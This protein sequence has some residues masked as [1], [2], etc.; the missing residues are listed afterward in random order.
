MKAVVFA[1]RV[2][3]AWVSSLLAV[4]V[5]APAAKSPEFTSEIR[6]IL[7]A[8]CW[9]CH[10]ENSP[11]ASLSLRTPESILKGGK[12]G[13][14]VKPGSSA[15]SLLIEKVVSKAMPPGDAKLSPAEITL[16]RSWVDRL[17][18]AAEREVTENDVLPIFQ[19]RCVVCHGKRK[20]EAGLDLRSQASRLRGGKSGPALVPGKPDQSLL[21]Q[22]ISSGQMPP[23]KLLFEYFVRPPTSTEVETLRKWIA[24][25][26][27][28]A[29]KEVVAETANDPLVSDQDRAFWSFQPP[30]RPAIPEVKNPDIVRN[31]IDAFLL[32]KLQAKNLTFS[33]AA[34][35]LVLLRRACLDLTGLPP[36]P[37]QIREYLDDR[38]PDAYERL[39]DRLLASPQYGERWAQFWLN[40]AGYADSEGIIDED[41]IRPNAWRYRDYVIRS[42]NSDKPYDQFLTE[43]IAGD[44]LVNYKHAKEITP[45]IIDKLVATGFLRLVP[46]GTYSPANG[47]VAERMNVIA[48]EIEVLSSSVMGL[49]V[50]CA[51]CHNHKYDPIP[52]RD[53]YRLSAILQTAYDP[54]DWVKPT[55]RNLDVAPESDRREVASFNEPIE[56]AIKR[57][58]KSLEEKAAPLR[59]KV[60][61]DRLASL[62]G[63]VRGDLQALLS[64]EASK[65]TPIQVYLADKFQETLKVTNEDLAKQFPEFKTESDSTNKSIAQEKKK[66]RE[67]PEIRALYEMGGDPSPAYLLRRGDAQSIGEAV[68]PGTPSVLRAGLI[69][70]KVTSPWEDAT[71][72]RLALARWLV[73]PNH[74]LTSRVI[75]NRIWMHHFGR[76]IVASPANFGRI[77]VSPSHPELLDWLATEFVR[78]GWSLKSLH[79]LIMTSSAYRQS[80]EVDAERRNLDAENILLSRMPLRRMEAEQLYDS[81]LEVTG[82]LD[83]TQF[84]PPVVVDTRAGGEIIAKGKKETGWRRAIYTLQRRTTPMT[85]LDVFDL[86]PMSPNCIERASSTVP[87]QALQMMNSGVFRDHARY[88]AGR[89]IDQFGDNQ[90]QQIEHAYLQAL[91]RR[92]TSEEVKNAIED[93]AKLTTQWE[94]YLKNQ[95][96]EAPRR[97]AAKWSAL[98]SFCHELL[99]SAEFAY[100]D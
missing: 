2:F 53:Y 91:S 66:L 94:S 67:K 88:W 52:Q 68:R 20:Q 64:T 42:L 31:P 92:P 56:A 85:M 98:A 3:M 40:A 86:P 24:A 26:A 69:P 82:R 13:P 7:Q 79:R 45:E 8:K 95:N 71:G 57:L 9:A 27:P 83:D 10:G 59:A 36:T 11:Q 61:G 12:S 18:G 72:R 49:T 96:D 89:L 15:G 21:M 30:K 90:E 87:T 23:P 73:Q 33:P 43:Q 93:I 100:I 84:G 99:N 51:R 41:R 14:A 60:I 70:Y 80:S 48:D 5:A 74:P 39:I 50:G 16:L 6:P 32:Q 77:G 34:E 46:D 54:Y 62:P 1:R 65:R 29:P 25:G 63:S 17:S 38:R 75:V 55:E 37:A 44:E 35:R 4:V 19:M 47:S 78:S 81:I 58:E 28:P 97:S 76:G 22:K